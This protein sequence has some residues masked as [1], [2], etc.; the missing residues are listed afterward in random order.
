MIV[1]D[2]DFIEACERNAGEYRREGETE[3]EYLI[4]L[5]RDYLGD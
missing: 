2:T 1:E 5:Q 3:T 4:R